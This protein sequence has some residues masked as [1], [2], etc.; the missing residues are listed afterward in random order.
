MRLRMRGE[1]VGLCM[2][3]EAAMCQ[4]DRSSRLTDNDGATDK[5]EGANGFQGSW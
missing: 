2:A 1:M 5:H 4:D 3:C